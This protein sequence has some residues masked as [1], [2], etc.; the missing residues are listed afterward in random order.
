MLKIEFLPKR[1]TNKKSLSNASASIY[2]NKLG[3][4]LCES[5]FKSFLFV[6]SPYHPC[7]PFYWWHI[8]PYS[9]QKVPQIFQ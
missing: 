6:F 4:I 8:I 9:P 1:L 5:R 2:G 7:T 3:L